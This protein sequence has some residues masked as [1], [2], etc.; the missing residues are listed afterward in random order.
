MPDLMR[1]LFPDK[2]KRR[3]V[4]E[5]INQSLRED[6]PAVVARKVIGVMFLGIEYIEDFE[7]KGGNKYGKPEEKGIGEAG[8]SR[9]G[10]IRP[11]NCR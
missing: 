11:D 6:P 9:S 7:D 2:L 1:Q 10:S 4:T 8:A 5:Y 3:V